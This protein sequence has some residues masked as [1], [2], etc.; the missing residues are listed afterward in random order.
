M[1][2]DSQQCLTATVSE[3]NDQE[4]IGRTNFRCRV[5]VR[6]LSPGYCA[7]L[8][9][10]LKSVDIPSVH[11]KQSYSQILSF[12]RQVS[13]SLE[14]IDVPNEAIRY[15]IDGLSFFKDNAQLRPVIQRL[16]PSAD[17]GIKETNDEDLDLRKRLPSNRTYQ[18]IV[19]SD[20]VGSNALVNLQTECTKPSVCT[21]NSVPDSS[22]ASAYLEEDM[23]QQS[24]DSDDSAFDQSFL[25]AWDATMID[26]NDDSWQYPQFPPTQGENGRAVFS[27]NQSPSISSGS[28][29]HVTVSPADVVQAESAQEVI[30]SEVAMADEDTSVNQPLQFFNDFVIELEQIDPYDFISAIHGG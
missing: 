29:L 10:D 18:P 27:S 24:V 3:S 15:E 4:R 9:G 28:A 22:A 16:V 7:R 23:E 21:P 8:S 19:L 25:D 2:I 20:E 11:S 14:R 26:W 1:L 5:M 17:E 12:D 6:R 30:S 13:V